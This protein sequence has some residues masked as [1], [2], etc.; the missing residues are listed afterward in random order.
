MRPAH[1]VF[2]AAVAAFL[3]A[4][5]GSAPAVPASHATASASSA[6]ASAS[7]SSATASASTSSAQPDTGTTDGSLLACGTV[8]DP[9][10]ASSGFKSATGT[11]TE[12][13]VISY[14][15]AMLL[16]DGIRNIPAGTPSSEDTAILSGAQLDLVNYH[17]DKLADDSEQF[18]EDEQSYHPS[19]PVDASYGRKLVLD[20]TALIKD[21][22]ASVKMAL[23][24]RGQA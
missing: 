6:T 12:V 11:L 20:I 15:E 1:H 18:A 2:P 13:Q 17:G 4:G 23:H 8:V 9:D 16:A 5:C 22:P 14:L 21:C 24:T 10:P 7:T 19:G 3:L